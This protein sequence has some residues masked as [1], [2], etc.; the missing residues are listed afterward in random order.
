MPGRS[1][2]P[3]RDR[4]LLTQPR[5]SHLNRRLLQPG[6]RLPGLLISILSFLY[7]LEFCPAAQPLAVPWKRLS[8]QSSHTG[9]PG[10]PHMTVRDRPGLFWRDTGRG[11]RS[12]GPSRPSSDHPQPTS[13]S[14]WKRPPTVPA[15]RVALGREVT[16]RRAG[17]A[18]HVAP[19]ARLPRTRT[20]GDNTSGQ[21]LLSPSGS[22][23]LHGLAT[24]LNAIY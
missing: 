23:L 22:P 4:W 14:L 19:A 9:G 21:A 13:T 18:A 12:R 20:R 24:G 6:V 11:G 8:P 2:A 17:R 10:C 7:P 15:R 3:S 5:R 1:A 16:A